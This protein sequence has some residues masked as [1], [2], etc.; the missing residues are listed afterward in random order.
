MKS[1]NHPNIGRS[2][3][4]GVWATQIHNEE[5]LNEAYN[6]CDHVILIFSVNSS[7]HFQGF[8]RMQSAIGGKANLWEGD[9][10]VGGAFKVWWLLLHDLHFAKV[11]QAH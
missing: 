11:S 8:A 3:Q 2:I 7:G 1:L 6:T 4:R 5:K 9:A 10:H